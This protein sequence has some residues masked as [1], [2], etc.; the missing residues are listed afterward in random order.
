MASLVTL[1]DRLEAAKRQ[2]GAPAHAAETEKLLTELG[3]RRFPDSASLIRFHETLLF[4]RAYPANAAIAN[5][6]D[7]LL[8]SFPERIRRPGID[9]DSFEEP[10]VSGIAGTAFSAIFSYDITRWLAAR[11]PS[12]VDI[13]WDAT[14]PSLLGPLL[15]LIRPF[16][17]EDALVE[18]N[19]PHLEWFRA[20]KKGPASDLSWLIS[21]LEQS[22]VD[23]QT[24]SDLFASAKIAVRWDLGR[25]AFTR[26][27][28]RLP[29]VRQFFYH[30]GP[31]LRRS[32]VSLDAELNS[33]KLPI[34][35]LTVPPA[36]NSSTLRAKPRPC[37]I[38]NCTGS[39]METP[40]G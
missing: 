6:A 37:A 39:P 32:D 17:A 30:D 21:Q 12:D 25:G 1:L 11:H 36:G 29:G 2:F 3:T 20:A 9:L 38:A 16:Y 22:A 33:P 31:I 10:D 14:D 5:L 40:R 4:L 27:N 7:Q 23:R 13:D 35:K 24:L 26:S 8:N 34:T 15:R 18:A 28:L 19:I